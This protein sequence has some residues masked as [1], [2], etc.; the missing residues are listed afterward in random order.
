MNGTAAGVE[1]PVTV[2]AGFS[3]RSRHHTAVVDRGG[4][5]P[6]ENL[7]RVVGMSS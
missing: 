2:V 6:G 5:P 3:W 1:L 4:D 7:V